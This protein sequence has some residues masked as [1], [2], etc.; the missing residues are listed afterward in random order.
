MNV[1]AI[2]G[3]KGPTGPIRPKHYVLTLICNCA[4]ENGFAQD[5]LEWAI[6]NRCQVK[7]VLTGDLATD[8]F[9]LMERYSDIV[10]AYQAFLLS[11]EKEA[12]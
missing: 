12:A 1:N 4:P 8:T 9:N 2:C 5:A 10:Q 11:P 7:V 6:H 3:Y